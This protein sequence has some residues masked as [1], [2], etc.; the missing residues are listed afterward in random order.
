M[1]RPRGIRGAPWT[2]ATATAVALAVVTLAGCAPL[3]GNSNGTQTGASGSHNAD[4]GLLSGLAPGDTGGSAG[5]ATTG[6]E[7]PVA[8]INWSPCQYGLQC[9]SVTVPLDYAEP[10]GP[11]IQIA[12]V[13]HLASDPSAR[14]GSLV[15]NPGGP[16]GSGVDDLPNELRVLTSGLVARFDIVSFDPRGVDRSSPVTC[17]ETGGPATQG[18][19]PDPAP[20]TV[21]A[22][23]SVLSNDEAYAKDCAK[24]T[25]LLLPFVGTVDAARDLDRIRAALGDAQL[26]YFGHSYGTLLGLTYADLF[27]THLRAMV[28]DGV[29]DPAITGEQMVVDQA[30]GFENNLNSFFSWCAASGCAWH[31]DGDPTGALLGLIAQAR[32]SPIPAG[33]G[34]TAGPGEIYTAVLSALYSPSSWSRLGYALAS[35]QAGNGA[36]I[37]AMSDAYD[38]NNGPNAVDANT[39]I[40]CLDHPVSRNPAEYPELAASASVQAPVFGPMLVWGLLECA[41]WPAMPTRAAHPVRADG[42]PPILVVGTSGDPATP[43]KWAASVATELAHGVLVTWQGQSHVAYYYSPCVRGIDQAYFIFGTLPAD[44]TVCTG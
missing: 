41:V 31:A 18:P 22:Q 17:G 2:T 12:L 35:A 15:I 25:G 43:H 27:P 34:R 14:I 39:A 24:A 42:A 16:G 32:Q 11:Q 36:G 6:S 8:P 29:I 23:E 1:S 4:G 21:A 19:L 37:V 9:G 44:G 10:D 20:P 7:P 26:T 28:L 13:R 3:S 33:G 38:T 30:V 5:A 40:S